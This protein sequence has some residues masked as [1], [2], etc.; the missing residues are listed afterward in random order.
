MNAKEL[1]EKVM[2]YVAREMNANGKVDPDGIVD[3]VNEASGAGATVAE[4]SAWCED[5]N[6]LNGLEY[7]DADGKRHAPAAA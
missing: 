1:V 3:F 7:Y 4:I 6:R 5:E 2:R